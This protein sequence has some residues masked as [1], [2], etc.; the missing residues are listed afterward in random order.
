METASGQWHLTLKVLNLLVKYV[1]LLNKFNTFLKK[2]TVSKKKD[3][4]MLTY[5]VLSWKWWKEYYQINY[6]EHVLELKIMTVQIEKAHWASNVI[7]EKWLSGHIFIKFWNNED[8]FP[9]L[10][11]FRIYREKSH[12]HRVGIRRSNNFSKQHCKLKENRAMP[13]KSWG[14]CF[15]QNVIFQNF[16]KF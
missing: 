15:P 6:I 8:D 14:K 2:H 9:S 13:S 10:K 12:I 16:S 7:S 5:G 11:C 1:Y 3:L 4:L